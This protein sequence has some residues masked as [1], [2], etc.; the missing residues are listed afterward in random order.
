METMRWSSSK[1]V[2]FVIKREPFDEDGFRIVHKATSQDESF[3]RKTWV[4]KKYQPEALEIFNKTNQT[5]EEHTKKRLFKCIAL[6]S[7]CAKSLR[8]FFWQRIVLKPI[9][10]D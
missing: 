8:S 2:E 9:G 10:K 7:K 4:V 6:Q 1:I 3:S 5:P